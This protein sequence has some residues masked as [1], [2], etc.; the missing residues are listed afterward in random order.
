MTTTRFYIT[1]NGQSL[2][3]VVNVQNMVYDAQVVTDFIS[4]NGK[5]IGR[6]GYGGYESERVI[7]AQTRT[8]ANMINRH[9][10]QSGY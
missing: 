10:D 5:T 7:F 6:I 9:M 3:V 4:R 2:E 1:Y 8:L